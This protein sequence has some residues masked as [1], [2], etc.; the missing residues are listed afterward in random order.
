MTGKLVLDLI[1]FMVESMSEADAEV[2]L[3][4]CRNVGLQLR[5]EDPDGIK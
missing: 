5:R 3:F 2:L 1:R 4:V